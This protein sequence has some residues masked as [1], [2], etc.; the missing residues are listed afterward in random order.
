MQQFLLP[1]TLCPDRKAQNTVLKN[2]KI[3]GLKSDMAGMLELSD[4]GFEATMI[5]ML[6]AMMNKYTMCKNKWT[7]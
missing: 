7:M 5:N 1:R 3:L 2:R 4:W 6:R